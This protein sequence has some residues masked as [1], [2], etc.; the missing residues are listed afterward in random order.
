MDESLP[1]NERLGSTVMVASVSSE[2]PGLPVDEIPLALGGSICPGRAALFVKVRGVANLEILKVL[3][4]GVAL[5]I[6]AL[7]VDLLGEPFS[8]TFVGDCGR[9]AGDPSKEALKGEFST[10]DLGA[11]KDGLNGD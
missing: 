9:L 8:A 1:E 7:V 5:K 11:G 2:D 10:A 4:L 6:E 3:T